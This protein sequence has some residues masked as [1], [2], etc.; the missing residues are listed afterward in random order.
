MK[1]YPSEQACIYQSFVALSQ[2]GASLFGY[3]LLLVVSRTICLVVTCE[4]INLSL[5]YNPFAFS[6]PQ[7]TR[8]V[9]PG[10]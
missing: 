9:S 4:G 1:Y 5:S 2:A 3:I 7:V 10:P 6:K 8:D